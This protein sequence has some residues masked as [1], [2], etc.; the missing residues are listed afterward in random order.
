VLWVGEILSHEL[1]KGGLSRAP[2]AVDVDGEGGRVD[3]VSLRLAQFDE[4]L[5]QEGGDRCP[6]EPVCISKIFRSCSRLD[7]IRHRTGRV[8]STGHDRTVPAEDD[9][10]SGRVGGGD[11]AAVRVP[12]ECRRGGTKGTR[13]FRTSRTKRIDEE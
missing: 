11:A 9:D 13:P 5:G 6:A 4:L 8:R 7:P 3:V 10:V 1:G 12:G 2:R